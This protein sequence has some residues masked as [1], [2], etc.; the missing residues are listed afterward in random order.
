[1]AGI[2]L[3]QSM[4][5]SKKNL[6]KF[7]LWNSSFLI[8]LVIF[9]IVAV[10]FGGMKWYEKTIDAKLSVLE[11]TLK[12][13]STQLHGKN[14]DRIADFDSRLSFIEN[15][16]SDSTDMKQ[17][18][19]QVEGLM[20]PSVVLTK[21]GYS[22]QDNTITIAGETN[23][24]RYLAQQIL[25]LKSA[26]TFS[27]IRVDNINRTSDGKIAFILRTNIPVKSK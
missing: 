4:Q 26:D 1:M 14:V 13:N 20:V 12:D 2:N 27:E 22:K 7:N 3:S 25:S 10:L 6:G 11:Q 5:E 23:N 8:S 17:V 15:N 21:Y 9:S 18:L 24:F 19:E 16:I